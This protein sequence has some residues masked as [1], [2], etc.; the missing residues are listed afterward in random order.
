MVDAAW[1]AIFTSRR[2]RRRRWFEL[3]KLVATA[4]TAMHTGPGGI[5]EKTMS[6]WSEPKKAT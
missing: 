6:L 1:L 3:G 5:I 4:I 2:L